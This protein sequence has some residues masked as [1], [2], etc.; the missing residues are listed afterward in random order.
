MSWAEEMATCVLCLEPVDLVSGPKDYSQLSDKGCIAINNANRLRKLDVPDI[1]CSD[2]CSM[3]VHK[4]C[5]SKHTNP[6]DIHA[7]S[8]RGLTPCEDKHTLRSN[9]SGFDFHT[10]CFLCGVCIDQEAARRNPERKI[11]QFS[12]VM[13]IVF[14]H[15][16]KESALQRRDDWAT[17]VE[18]RI[19]PIHDLPAEEALYHHQCN[20]NFRRGSSIPSQYGP[21]EEQQP[22]KMKLGRRKDRAKLEAFKLATDYLEANDDETITVEALHNIMATKS[23]LCDDELYSVAHMKR[24]LVNHYGDN[25][26]ITTIRQQPNIVTLSSNVS[27]IIQE[28]HV[29]AAQADQAGMETLIKLVG[30]YIRAEIKGMDKHTDVYPDTDQIKSVD[31]NM[32][33]LPQ[34]LRILLE[35]IIKSHNAVNMPQIIPSALA[36]RPQCEPRAQIWTQGHC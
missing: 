12:H 3:Q 22:K 7:A 34:S 23:G 11:L 33:Y 25:V 16:I 27:S 32:E 1:T 13:S 26:S 28:A 2:N 36:D 8:K 4:A 20:S 24:E 5:R 35:S 15:A 10:C 18:A 31:T 29:N 30:T 6:K 9:G 21:Q 14:K 17:T 19:A